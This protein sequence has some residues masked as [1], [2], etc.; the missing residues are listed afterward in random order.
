MW[1]YFVLRLHEK[2]ALFWDTKHKYRDSHE[3]DP[4]AIPNEW[5]SL[6]ELS[7]AIRVAKQVRTAVQVAIAETMLLVPDRSTA[8]Q[9]RMARIRTRGEEVTL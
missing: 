5:N 8:T 7:L 3:D 9:V 6:Y 2:G 4:K 1:G